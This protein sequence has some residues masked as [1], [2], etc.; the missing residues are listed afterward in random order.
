VL[1]LLRNRQG[2]ITTEL[3]CG[4]DALYYPHRKTCYLWETVLTLQQ[5]AE[6]C[7]GL[8]LVDQSCARLCL[9]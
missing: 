5:L 8:E 7:A 2:R 9:R 3:R 4:V 6:R 1:R